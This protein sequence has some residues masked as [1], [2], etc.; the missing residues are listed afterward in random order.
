MSSILSTDD[1]WESFVCNNF[2]SIDIVEDSCEEKANKKIKE[3]IPKPSDIYIS[4][5]TVM[6]YL[7]Q[8]IDLYDI[9]W[10][11]KVM[12]YQTNNNCIIKKQI[13]INC[14]SKEEVVKLEKN[15]K[16]EKEQVINNSKKIISQDIISKIDNPNARKLKFKD[17]RKINIGITK[18]DLTCLRK[19]KKG[20]FYNCF[21]VV[22]RIKDDNDESNAFK[23]IH[24][25]VFN[26]GKLK[27]PG[28]K[29][30]RLLYKAIDL[31]IYYMQPF[32]ETPLVCLKEKTHTV[33]INSNFTS[34][35]FINR[36]TF[37]EILK[38][39]YKIHTEYDPCSYPGIRCKFY[40]NE[41]HDKCDGICKCDNMCSRKGS[42]KGENNCLEISFMIFR[43]GSVLIVGNCDENVINI[44]YKFLINILKEEF[45]EIKEYI[46]LEVKPKP[47]K[48]NKRKKII[49]VSK[50]KKTNIIL[51]GKI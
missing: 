36:H 27:I 39:K 49:F 51:N 38:Y 37:S 25:K 2:N 35:F 7:N 45:Y 15:I 22:L 10:K 18:K 48:V 29:D 14:F 26:T 3:D 1:A 9:F 5:K 46:D 21:V 11:L 42:G 44:I 16:N 33:L 50:K 47:K 31:L 12:P 41:K 17:V 13:K 6:C 43:T 4:T 23:E 20:A 32:I 28:I 19:K 30:N 8:Y 24:I 34:N 40:H